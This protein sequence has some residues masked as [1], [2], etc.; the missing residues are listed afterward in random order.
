MK[1]V[2]YIKYLEPDLA[3]G[4]LLPNGWERTATNRYGRRHEPV[5]CCV[6]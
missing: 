4:V 1:S 6:F 5:S 3:K 2:F